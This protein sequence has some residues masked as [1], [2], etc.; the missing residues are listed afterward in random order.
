[1]GG[2]H[3]AAPLVTRYRVATTAAPGSFTPA[4]GSPV[5]TGSRAFSVALG[6]VNGD[7]KLDLVTANYGANSV[8]VLLGNRDG[9]FTAAAGSPVAVGSC[10][11]SVAVG[12]VNGDGKLDLTTVNSGSNN[13]TVLLGNGDGTFTAPGGSPAVGSNS[14]FGAL[15]D[16]NGDGKLDLVTANY[17]SN[18]VTVLL[19]NGNGTFTAAS[20]SPV[21]VGFAPN[22]VALGDVNGDGKLDLVVANGDSNTL[23]VMLGIGDG[24]FTAAAGS[25]VA[26]GSGPHSVALGDLNG[27]GKLDLVA[28]N[29]LSINVT[30]L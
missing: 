17:G 11:Y 20:G 7:G 10:P 12:D 19:G 18:N 1:S 5:A 28:A 3:L 2:A 29:S 15:G 14:V 13:V 8:T 21:T 25:P 23:T 22:S 24:T 9:T 30:V 27:D 26:V 6:D 16:V 4:S